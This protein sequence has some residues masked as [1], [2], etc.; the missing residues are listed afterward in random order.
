M[1]Q[2]YDEIIEPREND[3]QRAARENR[4]R[5]AKISRRFSEIDRARIRPLAAIVAGVGTAEDKSRLKELEEEAAQ[6]RAE[7]AD[8]EDKDENN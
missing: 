5:A 8:M 1:S 2:N 3:E 7:L 6:L 4:L